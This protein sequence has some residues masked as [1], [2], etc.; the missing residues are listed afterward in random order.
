MDVRHLSITCFAENVEAVVRVL[1]QGKAELAGRRDA[2]ASGEAV[3]LK[4]LG[5][6]IC[7]AAFAARD[8][9]GAPS[10]SQAC[11]VIERAFVARAVEAC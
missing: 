8:D 1:P 11:I 9:R 7:K 5:R 10:L 3:D 4:E 6:R 2:Q